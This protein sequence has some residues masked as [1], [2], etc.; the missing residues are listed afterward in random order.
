ML[1]L[2]VQDQL[3][4]VRMGTPVGTQASRDGRTRAVSQCGLCW[5]SSGGFSMLC[6]NMSQYDELIRLKRSDDMVTIFCTCNSCKFIQM[7]CVFLK[8]HDSPRKA[9]IEQ[10]SGNMTET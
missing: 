6:V 4:A 1:L 8:Q 5:T 3:E 2:G 10:S 9:Q 7:M